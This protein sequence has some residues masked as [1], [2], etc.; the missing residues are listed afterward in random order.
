MGERQAAAD[1]RRGLEIDN[2]RQAYRAERDALAGRVAFLEEELKT[3][4][5]GVDAYRQALRA[6]T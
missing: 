6:K 4:R 3:A 5:S 2:L 1:R